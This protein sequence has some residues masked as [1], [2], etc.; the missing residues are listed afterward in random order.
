MAIHELAKPTDAQIAE[1]WSAYRSVLDA[2]RAGYHKPY[3]NTHDDE[4]L[5]EAYELGFY[6]ALARIRREA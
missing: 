1:Y 2:H 5:G 3:N 6:D 4:R